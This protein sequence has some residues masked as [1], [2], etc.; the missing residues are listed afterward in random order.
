ML[1]KVANCDRIDDKCSVERV[2]HSHHLG[3]AVARLSSPGGWFTVFWLQGDQDRALELLEDCAIEF[4]DIDDKRVC[5]PNM[6]YR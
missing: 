5:D 1:Q 3:V 2:T 4:F 6:L